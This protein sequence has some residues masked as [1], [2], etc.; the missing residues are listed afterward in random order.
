M[1]RDESSEQAPR[2]GQSRGPTGGLPPGTVSRYRAPDDK[3]LREKI[4]TELK[5]YILRVNPG[6]KPTGRVY[7]TTVNETKEVR[8]Y[9]PDG[10]KSDTVNMLRHMATT[11]L[12]AD[13]D[14]V[15]V[16]LGI[17]G[18]I[19]YIASNTKQQ[20]LPEEESK[21]KALLKKKVRKETIRIKRHRSKLNKRLQRKKNMRTKYEYR[22]VRGLEGQHAEIKLV[23]DNKYLDTIT[24]VN[25]P[26]LA[27]TI[28][29]RLAGVLTGVYN[30]HVGAYWDSK[31]ALM[32]IITDYLAAVTMTS[33]K[34]IKPDANLE[35][36]IIRSII[37]TVIGRRAVIVT[38]SRTLVSNGPLHRGEQKIEPAKTSKN[39]N[40][41]SSV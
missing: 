16:Q 8:V 33:L 24:G 25:R 9:G 18:D 12:A 28:Y 10:D 13:T 3:T 27:C 39:L 2:A 34:L 38:T 32:P 19:I 15:E 31:N 30:N 11:I 6:L 20:E 1:T 17:M 26:C 36:E 23:K 41:E 40:T 7:R 37:Q 14:R 29:M 35:S 4:Y 5:E 22:I 21:L